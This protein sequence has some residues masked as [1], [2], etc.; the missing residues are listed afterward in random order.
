MMHL[1]YHEHLCI[2]SIILYSGPRSCILEA[3]TRKT[4]WVTQHAA[5]HLA[6]KQRLNSSDC[7]QE[8][9]YYPA[10]SVSILGAKPA[11]NRSV[12]WGT[13]LFEA[14]FAPNKGSFTKRKP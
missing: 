10:N 6:G 3:I 4:A 13:L 1:L 8:K 5:V 12:C 2:N 7:D 14:G 9:D 11:T